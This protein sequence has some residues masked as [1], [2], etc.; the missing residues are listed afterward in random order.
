MVNVVWYVGYVEQLSVDKRIFNGVM[1]QMLGDQWSGW[2]KLG[3]QRSGEKNNG[4][5]MDLMIN[6]N[7][8]G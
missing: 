3:G 1:M 6:S 4:V 5:M 2:E 8:T 7:S